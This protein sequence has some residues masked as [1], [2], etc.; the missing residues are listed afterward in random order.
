M[1]KEAEVDLTIWQNKGEMRRVY[2]KVNSLIEKRIVKALKKNSIFPD[3]NKYGVEADFSSEEIW[4]IETLIHRIYTSTGPITKNESLLDIDGKLFITKHALQLVP[5]FTFKITV[6]GTDVKFFFSEG[7]IRKIIEKEE[8]KDAISFIPLQ[9]IKGS[10]LDI[11]NLNKDNA[12]GKIKLEVEQALGSIGFSKDE[13]N[14]M[15]LGALEHDSFT[16]D[17]SSEDFVGLAL[18]TRREPANSDQG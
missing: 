16:S 8:E 4:K 18:K 2:E 11:I 3:T 7:K 5:S 10:G 9:G 17:M 1:K 12:I 14:L 15:I 6:K 13:R